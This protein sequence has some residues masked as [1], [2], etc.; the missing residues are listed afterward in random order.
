MPLLF[1]IVIQFYRE[2]VY[3]QEDDAAENG[4]ER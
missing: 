4:E 2:K 1:T 3:L